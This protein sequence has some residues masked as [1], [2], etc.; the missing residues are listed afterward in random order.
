MA[1]IDTTG[2]EP[3]ADLLKEIY[4]DLAKPGVAQVGIALATVIGLINTCL[5][6]IKFLN[7]K[8]ELKRQKNLEHLANRL[9]EIPIENV[10]EVPPEIAIPIA[11]KL[12]Y[13]SNDEL[14]NM[15]IELLA[16]ASTKDLNE[17]AHPSFINII[18]SISPDEAILL[19]ILNK[20]NHIRVST[21]KKRIKNR[22][23]VFYGNFK[24][25]EEFDDIIFA[26]NFSAY[27]Q[28][29]EGLGIISIIDDNSLQVEHIKKIGRFIDDKLKY[30]NSFRSLPSTTFLNFQMTLFVTNYGRLFLKSI[31]PVD[32]YYED[33]FMF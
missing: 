9:S 10:V 30:P 28:N 14:R 26:Q 22:T 25:Y 24:H 5:S 20:I 27:L 3:F 8:T 33:E 2:L 4:G 23:E 1:I 13:V 17:N 31:L 19:K 32:E 15:Y 11:E 6:P 12:V 16:K 29:F 21:T 18:N 7:D